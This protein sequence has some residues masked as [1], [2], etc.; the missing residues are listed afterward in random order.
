MLESPFLI[1]IILEFDDELSNKIL[2]E[3]VKANKVV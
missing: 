2:K 3:F 1:Q